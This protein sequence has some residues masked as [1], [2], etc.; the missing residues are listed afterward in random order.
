MELQSPPDHGEES[1][2]ALREAAS[3]LSRENHWLI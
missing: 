2:E 1:V 3:S